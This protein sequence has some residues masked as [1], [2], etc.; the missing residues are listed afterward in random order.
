MQKRIRAAVTAAAIIGLGIILSL[1]LSYAD[2][3]KLAYLARGDKT[4]RVLVK[5]FV[6]ESGQPQIVPSDF[7]K[8]FE[9]ALLNRRSVKFQIAKS[10]E[11]SDIEISG[12]IK[13]YVYSKTDP[14]TTYASP[15]GLLL[16]AMTTENY[17]EMW[18]EF[19]VAETKTG[20]TVWKDTVSTFIKRPMTPDESIPLIYNKLSRHFLW[21]SF[22]KPK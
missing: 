16:D 5:D 9:E 17:V 19:T 18:L 12:V 10:P 4:V 15:S 6:N 13:K 3:G 14:I 20:H 2:E 8:S 7:K 1:G 21:K 22:G 11:A